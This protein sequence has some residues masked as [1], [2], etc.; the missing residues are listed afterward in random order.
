MDPRTRY[1]L[2]EYVNNYKKSMGVFHN[3]NYKC[4]ISRLFETHAPILCEIKNKKNAMNLETKSEHT[5]EDALFSSWYVPASHVSHGVE[6]VP[7]EV[8]ATQYL[9]PYV[10][11]AVSS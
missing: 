10:M 6:V 7:N 3:T 4:E 11:D 9:Q 5:T 8:P 2:Q 1:L